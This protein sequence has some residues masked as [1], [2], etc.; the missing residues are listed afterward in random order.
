MSLRIDL[1][2]ALK[3]R[4][5]AAGITYA[6]L[7]RRVG[8][9]EAA[10]KR[11]FSKGTMTLTRVEQ[12]CEVLGV[13]LAELAHDLRARREPL[14]ELTAQ[15]EEEL[16]RDQN[17]LLALYLVLN[18]WRDEDVLAHYRFEPRQWNACLIR[19]A[20]MGLIDLGPNNRVKLRTAR[21]FRWRPDGPIQR[22]F[23]QR[24]LPQYF[25]RG[26][27]GENQSLRLLTGMMTQASIEHVEHLLV[28]LTKAFDALLDQ[29]AHWPV[30]K[31]RGI[32]V[33]VA[34]RPWELPQFDA[35]RRAAGEA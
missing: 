27:R 26:F 5:R 23:E 12:V 33:V 16:V 13:D 8:L 9:S 34:M 35:I 25:A 30:A 19:L 17:L 24:L 6:S 32:S 29:D 15:H 18:R 22:Y 11:M 4:L 1:T 21:N 7:A 20:R 3:A 10:V 14:G 28:E 2:A 31:R